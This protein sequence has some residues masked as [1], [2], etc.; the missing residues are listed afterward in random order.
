MRSSL[1]FLFIRFWVVWGFVLFCFFEIRVLYTSLLSWNASLCRPT[2][3]P[4]TPRSARLPLWM[5]ELKAALSRP[6]SI[7]EKL[8]LALFPFLLASYSG[9]IFPHYWRI[10]LSLNCL[11]SLPLYNLLDLPFTSLACLPCVPSSS[12]HLTRLPFPHLL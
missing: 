3:W 9:H 8:L 4:S 5:L 1:Q 7:F 11:L 2:P 6:A 12:F 10:L